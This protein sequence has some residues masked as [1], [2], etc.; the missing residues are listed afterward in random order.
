ML[1]TVLQKNWT[2]D[3]LQIVKSYFEYLHEMIGGSVINVVV[4]LLLIVLVIFFWY[5][6]DKYDSWKYFILS[7]ASLV[8]IL[9]LYLRDVM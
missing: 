5:K 8:S 4:L 2:V 9:V 1:L 7:L 3:T 6:T